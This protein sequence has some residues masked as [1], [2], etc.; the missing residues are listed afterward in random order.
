MIH[1]PKQE[2]SRYMRRVNRIPRLSAERERELATRWR[3]RG[4]RQAADE[5]VS[6]HL[7]YVVVLAL[8]YRSYQVGLSDLI[9]EGNLGLL[10]ALDKFDPDRGFRFVTYATFWIRARIVE[11]ALGNWSIVR[12][13]SPALR[14]KTFFK[15][16]RERARAI[17]LHGEG[18]EADRALA[19]RLGVTP[20]VLQAMLE[21]LDSRDIALDTPAFSDSGTTLLDTMASTDPTQEDV[22]AEHELEHERGQAVAAALACLDDR[23]RTIV[24]RRL[25]AAAED[26]LSLAERGRM[27]GVSRERVRQLEA[28][29]KEKLRRH[30]TRKSRVCQMDRITVTDAAPTQLV[31]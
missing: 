13:G 17:N 12:A 1:E 8:K 14:S 27:M 25:M 29:A 3:D 30:I 18:P 15:L 23:E 20:G 6:A 26:E 28:R 22:F 9:A 31:A 10:K 24:E 5:L 4:D 2:L 19:Q 7:R 16:R 21:R 11:T